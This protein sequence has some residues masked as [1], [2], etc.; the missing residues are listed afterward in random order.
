ML[1]EHAPV[2]G[3]ITKARADGGFRAVVQKLLPK[4]RNVVRVR[5]RAEVLDDGHSLP[6]MGL[7]DLVSL[8]M[9]LVPEG[10]RRALTATQ[11]V[12]LTLKRSRSHAIVGTSA[13]AAAALVATPIPFSDAALLVPV[14]VAM[15]AGITATYGLPASEGFLSAVVGSAM[16]GTFATITGRTIVSALFKLFPGPGTVIG[17]AISATTAVAV[18]T[19]FGKAYIAALDALFARTP[20]R[21][22]S[23]AEVLAEL[24]SRWSGSAGSGEKG[25]RWYQIWK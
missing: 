6:P 23:T 18:T 8:T 5:A 17:A 21:M 20:G 2:V 14:Q 16:T 22:P 24:K 4:A 15:I 10:C 11:K 1:A 9:E 7:V 3:V 19:A 13:A 12:D 25:R